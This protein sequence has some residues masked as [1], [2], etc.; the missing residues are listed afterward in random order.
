MATL[1][2]QL[3]DAHRQVRGQPTLGPRWGTR[4][5]GTA[6]CHICE[7]TLSLLKYNPQM[8]VQIREMAFGH[9]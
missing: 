3:V 2:E 9:F 1:E 4:W 8:M 7:F 5:A 6:L